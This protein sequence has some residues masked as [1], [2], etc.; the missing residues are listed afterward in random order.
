M[1]LLDKNG[2]A[3]PKTTGKLTPSKDL[4]VYLSD[5]TLQTE[6]ALTIKFG[7]EALAKSARKGKP[8][9]TEEA[10]IVLMG[11]VFDCLLNRKPDQPPKA[12]DKQDVN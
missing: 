7:L 5:H 9:T 3:L 8:L 2:T 11:G 1:N 4:L 10:A 6:V 12:K